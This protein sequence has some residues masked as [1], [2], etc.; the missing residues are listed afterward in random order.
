[1][2][3]FTSQGF[4][5]IVA[6]RE[7]PDSLL[8]RARKRH[9][10]EDLFP[11]SEIIELETADYR[12]RTTATRFEVDDII[13]DYIMNIDYDNFKNSVPDFEYRHAT[14]RVWSTMYAYGNSGV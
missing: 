13:S 14:G 5:S 10:L 4:L 1:M 8:V 11:D 2:W 12:F 6:H 3:I 7:I 9:H